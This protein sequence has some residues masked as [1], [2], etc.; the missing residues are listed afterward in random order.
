MLGVSVPKDRFVDLFL[1]SVPIALL[2]LLSKLPI[3]Y[4]LRRCLI[5][6]PFVVTIAVFFPFMEE[7]RDLWSFGVGG[8]TFSITDEGMLTCLNSLFKFFLTVMALLVLSSTTRFNDLLKGLE[9]MRTPK[10]MIIQLSF[11]YRYFFL[12]IDQAM[13]MKRARDARSF[14]GRGEKRRQLRAAGGIIGVLFLRS[15]GRAARIYAAMASRGF[16]G[17]IKTLS[18]LKLSTADGVFASIFLI[19]LAGVWCAVK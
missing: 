12:V 11:L 16:D 3:G 17:S 18:R 10:I 2:L 14:G 1:Y 5:V 19:Y 6:S 9:L 13:R 7:G 15:Y 8:H 4:L